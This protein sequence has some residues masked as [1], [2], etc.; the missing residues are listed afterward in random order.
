M[1]ID[2]E[3][4]SAEADKRNAQFLLAQ[5]STPKGLSPKL[6]I[7]FALNLGIRGIPLPTIPE[8]RAAIQGWLERHP[9]KQRL[10]PVNS[11]D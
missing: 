9:L 8:H 10:Y 1:H 11:G 6:S 7:T 3:R 2:G 5:R 4:N